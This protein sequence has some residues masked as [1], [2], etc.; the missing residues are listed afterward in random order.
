MFDLRGRHL[1]FGRVHILLKL[2]GGHV[3]ADLGHIHLFQLRRGN[4]RADIGRQYL[5]Q[6]C[7]RHLPVEC[8]SIN[9]R[10]L[11]DGPV[12][13]NFGELVHELQCG[14]LPTKFWPGILRELRG[15]KPVR[16]YWHV[17]DHG[18]S[19]RQLLWHDWTLGRVGCLC[20]WLLFGNVGLDVFGLRRGDLRLEHD[21]GFVHELL[22]GL[23]S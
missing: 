8:R 14:N 15:W 3:R 2:R 13:S 17:N 11:F 4:L 19:C 1:L 7:S 21:T 23:L 16:L 22:T 20:R 5:L 6:L 10:E 12:F 18:V 9:V